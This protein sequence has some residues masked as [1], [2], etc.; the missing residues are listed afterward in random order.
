MAG[1]QVLDGTAAS[2]RQSAIEAAYDHFRVDRKGNLVSNTTLANYDYVVQPFLDWL[3]DARPGVQAFE[4][5]DVAVM[6]D[7]RLALV[8]R[9]ST[10]TDRPLQ[11]VTILDVP[12]R[13][14]TFMR[15]AANEQYGIDSRILTL[16]PP[17]A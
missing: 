9:V 5:L 11:P 4:D 13:L 3:R 1:M 17:R 6:R 8:N 10:P 15:W 12:R 2:R 7:Y 14:L 16:K